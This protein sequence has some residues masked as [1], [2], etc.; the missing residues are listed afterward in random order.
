MIETTH[1][2]M[3]TLDP[4]HI[5]SGGYTLGRVDNA[6]VREPGTNLPKIPGT[7]LLGAARTY[8][9]MRYGKTSAAGQH[10]SF[11]GKRDNCP[12][13][14]TFGTASESGGGRAGTVSI[15]DARLLFFPVS[16]VA[17]P[18]W[19]STRTTLEAAGFGVEGD[20]GA[21]TTLKCEKDVVNLGWLM[22]PVKKGLHITT[23]SG[24]Q[25]DEIKDRIV[26]ISP[27]LFSEV[28]N[29]NLEVRTSVAI[30]PETGTAE[31]K[32]LFTYEAIP[33]A[34]WLWCD[35]IENDYRKHFPQTKRQFDGESENENK[36]EPLGE[37]WSRPLHVIMAGL[38]LMKD[39]GVGGMNT[40]GFGR[41][42][43]IYSPEDELDAES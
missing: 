19:V 26:L 7:S 33:R 30:D 28:V 6:I 39:L 17:G 37:T 43:I 18:I 16:S 3:M 13:I 34:T 32:A 9:A 35:L 22:V 14:Y 1:V 29:S 27:Q 42:E 40:R 2:V 25:C 36:G 12:I 21:S 4:V 20:E 24:V 41:V 15:S 11:A 5:G 31:D 8:A 10:K 38:A 23:P